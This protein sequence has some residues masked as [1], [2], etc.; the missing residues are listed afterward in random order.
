MFTVQKTIIPFKVVFYFL[1]FHKAPQLPQSVPLSSANHSDPIPPHVPI[2]PIAL[3]QLSKAST[4]LLNGDTET[5][6][7]SL[8]LTFQRIIFD[9]TA[10]VMWSA[11]T[12]FVPGKVSLAAPAL[13]RVAHFHLYIYCILLS[14]SSPVSLPY[15][16]LPAAQ[17]HPSPT[18]VWSMTHS[19]SQHLSC[20]SKPKSKSSDQASCSAQTQSISKTKLCDHASFAEGNFSLATSE[21]SRISGQSQC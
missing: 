6:T 10:W 13:T 16:T 8:L 1:L 4:V 5:S 21:H 12:L 18:D 15:H 19:A 20:F 2:F 11:F 3:L 17:T 14:W 9:N 7:L